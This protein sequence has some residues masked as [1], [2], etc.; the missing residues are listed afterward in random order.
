MMRAVIYARYSTDMQRQA[1]IDDQSE[2]CRR[3]IESQGWVLVDTYA[4]PAT[5]GSSAFR[6][7]FQ[8]LCADVGDRLYPA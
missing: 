4:D 8:R 7:G 5:S 1:S 6:P 2:V 3:Y